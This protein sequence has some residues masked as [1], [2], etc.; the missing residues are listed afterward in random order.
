MSDIF[1]RIYGNNGNTDLNNNRKNN[2][3]EENNKVNN[4]IPLILSIVGL[5]ISLFC[6]LSLAFCFSYD[7]CV[8]LDNF[9]IYI[10]CIA[11]VILIIS[12]YFSFKSI[13][14]KFNVLSIIN[15]IMSLIAIVVFIIPMLFGMVYFN[16]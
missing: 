4:L 6:I 12:I 16:F 2:D 13:K 8:F 9:Y 1:D 14:E 11:G 15:L 10:A 7:L 5:I 3:E